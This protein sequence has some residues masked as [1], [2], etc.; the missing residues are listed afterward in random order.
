MEVVSGI[1]GDFKSGSKFYLSGTEAFP[2]MN[3]LGTNV[4]LF[5][6]CIDKNIADLQYGPTTGGMIWNDHTTINIIA[7]ALKD[8]DASL[9]SNKPREKLSAAYYLATSSKTSKKNL[10][11]VA[12]ALIWGLEQREQEINQAAIEA[13]LAID[14][15]IQK[16]AG[17]YHPGYRYELKKDIAGK[18][19]NWWN[20]KVTSD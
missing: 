15:D 9:L 19:F 11:K 13:F 20:D 5:L 14:I 10:N 4:T 17:S 6:R 2:F 18:M 3:R 7:A 12:H 8:P 1:R 16:V